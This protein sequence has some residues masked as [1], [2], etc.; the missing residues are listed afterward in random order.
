MDG[1]TVVR[2]RCGMRSWPILTPLAS[3]KLTVVLFVMSIF[4]V[5]AGTLAQTEKDIWQVMHDY[6]R[7]DLTS[8]SAA[9]AVPHWPGLIFAFSF[10]LRSFRRWSRSRGATVSGFPAAG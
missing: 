6:F 3:L 10:R 7:M 4:I 9:A 2:P 8:F 1:R 5:L